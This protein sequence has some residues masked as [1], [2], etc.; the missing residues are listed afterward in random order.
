MNDAQNDKERMERFINRKVTVKQ[1]I[2]ESV[3]F[4]VLSA[5]WIVLCC[6]A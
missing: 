4:A 6:M 3:A 2:A 5:V 1:V